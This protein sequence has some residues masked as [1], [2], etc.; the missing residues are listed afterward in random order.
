LTLS[1][2]TSGLVV[3]LQVSH[4]CTQTA[5]YVH[6]SMGESCHYDMYHNSSNT[7]NGPSIQLHKSLESTLATYVAPHEMGSMLCCWRP[8]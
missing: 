1:E 5:H 7:A 4:L 2:F 3:L 6:S 8:M